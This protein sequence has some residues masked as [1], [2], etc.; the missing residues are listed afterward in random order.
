LSLSIKRR[1]TLLRLQLPVDEPAS[2]SDRS[3]GFANALCCKGLPSRE[4]GVSCIWDKPTSAKVFGAE[5]WLEKHSGWYF[6]CQ[7]RLDKPMY[8]FSNF[9]AERFGKHV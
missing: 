6:S 1:T 5:C 3:V 2:D 8:G 7:R 4:L 9:R